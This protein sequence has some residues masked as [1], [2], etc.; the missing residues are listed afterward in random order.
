MKKTS[1]AVAVMP[2]PAILEALRA[3]T[4]AEHGF[5]RNL[6]PRLG[7]FSQ[8][9]IEGKGKTQKVVTEAGMYF[10]DKPTGKE[11]KNDEGKLVKEF[12]KNELGD[13]IEGIIL[14]NRKQ[15]RHYDEATETYTSSPIF[16]EMDQV[17]PL[18][19][20]KQEIA[21]GTP[22]QLKARPEYQ[23][24]KEGKT[25]SSLEENR[26]LYV[27]YEEEIHEMN[28]R[29]SS[30][31]AFLKY[32]RETLVP[33]V[34]TKFTSESM[35]KGKISWNKMKFEVIEQLNQSQCEDVL[36]KVKEIKE[37]I[38]EQKGFYASKNAEA[39]KA[40]DTAQK[41]LDKF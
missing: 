34:M 30:M 4:P 14:F 23:Y 37:G 40:E 21:R 9:V 15:L 10:T 7:M 20:N 3:E 41:S 36:E 35:E 22:E 29:G 17:I 25:K 26:I 33:S 28:I 12:E 16:D 11:V 13:S 19:R 39:V 18:F 6:F 27:L 8:D 32:S 5:T 2:N 1:T 31:F 38:A 24:E